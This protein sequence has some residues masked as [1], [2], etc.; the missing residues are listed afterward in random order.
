MRVFGK[1]VLPRADV[2]IK[3]RA[4]ACHEV[5]EAALVDGSTGEGVALRD[6]QPRGCSSVRSVAKDAL[7]LVDGGFL[8][9]ARDG[10]EEA[11]LFAWPEGP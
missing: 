2:R 9:L 11:A 8:L 3:Q 10:V 1:G 7:A 4:R 5:G 6:G